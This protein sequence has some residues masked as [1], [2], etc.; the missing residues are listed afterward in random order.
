MNVYV[1]AW[2]RFRM[3]SGNNVCLVEF[4]YATVT[5]SIPNLLVSCYFD[6]FTR[7]FLN[8]N[9]TMPRIKVNGRTTT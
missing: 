7:I 5:L 4:E 8:C 3:Y 9:S 1:N 6:T 2:N